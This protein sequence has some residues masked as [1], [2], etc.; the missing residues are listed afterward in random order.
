M[1]HSLN[2]HA[3]L[4]MEIRLNKHTQMLIAHMALSKVDNSEPTSELS[5]SFLADS[6]GAL[7]EYFSLTTIVSG[8]K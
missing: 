1:K 4:L 6:E 3:H 5:F 2:K 7:S 8:G